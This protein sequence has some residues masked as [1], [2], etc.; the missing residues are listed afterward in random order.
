MADGRTLRVS[1]AVALGVIALA[2]LGGCAMV[3]PKSFLDPT[4]VGRFWLEPHETEILRVLSPLETPPG[5]VGANEP[6]PEDLV[7]RYDEYRLSPGDTLQ[8]SILDLLT[9]GVPYEAVYEVSPLGEIRLPEVGAVRVEGLTEREVEQELRARLV[10]A[11]IL[12]RP[13]VTVFSQVR[14]GRVVMAI[15]AFRQSGPYP[16]T[17]P[18]MRMLDLLGMAGDV[19]PSARRAYVIRRET[20]NT[21]APRTEPPAPI[22]NDGELLIEPPDEDIIAPVSLAS[23]EG[24]GQPPTTEPA[25]PRR[26]E[27]EDLMAQPRVRTDT[28]PTGT[29][30]EPGITP[31]VFDPAT[32]EVLSAPTMRREDA[33]APA[34]P[35]LIT[36][37]NYEQPFDWDAITDIG[38]RQRVI[39]IDLSQLKAGVERFN[40]VLQ[41]RDTVNVPVDVGVFY[42]MG[43]V[44]RP[45][46]YAFGGR[47]ITV[48]Q[49]IAIAGGMSP[50]A[51]PMRAE[52]IRREPGTDKQTTIPVNLDA[53]FAG[54]QE[55]FFMRDEDILNVGTSIVAPFLFVIRNSFRF[56]YGFGFVYDRN[57]A[58]QDA[59][60]GRPNPEAVRLQQRSSRGLLF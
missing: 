19:D 22:R 15:G 54:L 25:P 34:L 29:A 35:D 10:E 13:V 14:R 16:I 12:P 45:G 3:P 9:A 41:N 46:V 53:I 37:E 38:F 24:A 50:L 17:D 51:W 48:K 52:V 56:T 40:I 44:V 5:I 27:L 6:R 2:G 18:N 1:S 39:E 59:Y 21:T 23:Q 7:A 57:F 43:E 30:P 28:Q 36:E 8:I 31:F 42:M 47:Q 11:R 26:E 33:L 55:D 58:D 32:G 49:A 20:S 4:K 60:G